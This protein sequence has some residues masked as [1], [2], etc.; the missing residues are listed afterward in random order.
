MNNPFKEA[1]KP[2]LTLEGE[3][4]ANI[5][6]AQELGQ[7]EGKRGIAK[8]D[9][10]LAPRLEPIRTWYNTL[11]KKHCKQVTD[12]S[13]LSELESETYAGKRKSLEEKL[14][15]LK[16]KRKRLTLN[17][18]AGGIEKPVK[19]KHWWAYLL[20]GANAI[21]ESFFTYKSFS[22]EGNSQIVQAA[23]FIVLIGIFIGIPLAFRW[24]YQTT[25]DNPK[26]MF[27][28]GGLACIFLAGFY[29]FA[30]LRA[31]FL[32]NAGMLSIESEGGSSF[33]ISP[34]ALVVVQV[35]FLCLAIMFSMM[36]PDSKKKGETAKA[37]KLY[38]DIDNVEIQIEDM[39]SE[40][41]SIPERRL[42]AERMRLDAIT[43]NANTE[44]RIRAMYF[45][46]VEAYKNSCLQWAIERPA[47]FDEVT[48]EL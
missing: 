36:I 9:N 8:N 15:E 16:D 12:T 32:G 14:G 34:V 40:L 4:E 47:C 21:F 17:R 2:T 10:A 46:C 35:M 24:L 30:L 48:P 39:E 20:I 37:T 33:G 6:K 18:D 42:Q 29:V 22:F 11:L 25:K 44:A 41:Q 5:K 13:S 7:N 26:R 3:H 45:E 19:E 28:W 23:I 31:N 38:D 1:T 43:R 27:Y